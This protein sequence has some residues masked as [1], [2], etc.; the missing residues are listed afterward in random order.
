MIA[1]MIF[2]VNKIPDEY[3]KSFNMLLKGLTLIAHDTVRAA[4]VPGIGTTRARCRP[5]KRAITMEEKQKR[6]NTPLEICTTI[7]VHSVVVHYDEG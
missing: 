4:G 5:W 3:D 7:S 1:S 6:E 2:C